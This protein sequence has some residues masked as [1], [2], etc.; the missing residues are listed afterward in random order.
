LE[1]A[2]YIGTIEIGEDLSG[3]SAFED[4]Y[5]YFY[6]DYY[7]TGSYLWGFD[8]VRDAASGGQEMILLNLNMAKEYDF[9][10]G[11]LQEGTYRAATDGAAG[12]FIKGGYEN[13]EASGSACMLV[14]DGV[15]VSYFIVGGTLTIGAR[16]AGGYTVVADF[17]LLNPA[18]NLT[19]EGHFKYEGV[20]PL[21]N[22]ASKNRV[23]DAT[24]KQAKA[25]WYG[26]TINN[27]YRWMLQ[28]RW[29]VGEE[30]YFY[31]IEIYSAA[32][33][34][35]TL[36]TGTFNM[37]A[38]TGGNTAGTMEPGYETNGS[39]G[40]TW[41][42][43]YWGEAERADPRPAKPGTGSVTITARGGGKYDIVSRFVDADNNTYNGTYT[44]GEVEIVD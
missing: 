33:D 30:T 29:P 7:N 43:S 9:A 11:R 18:T 17:E 16:E 1:V 15:R 14:E 3:Y 38:A 40:G 5:A 42:T 10:S 8:L 19:A 27:S 28:L 12:T 36:P 21:N 20:P 39:R 32:G 24:I 41:F 35:T 26:A 44:N 25:W 34:G 23:W 37:A 6:D 22:K 4:G 31:L 13:G 2:N